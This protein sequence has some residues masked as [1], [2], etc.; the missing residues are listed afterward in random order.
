MLYIAKNRNQRQATLGAY[1]GL[2]LQKAKETES[3]VTVLLMELYLSAI[4]ELR[5]SNP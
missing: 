3:K 5:S 4:R 2:Q 1:N